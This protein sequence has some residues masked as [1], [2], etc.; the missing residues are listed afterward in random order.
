MGHG[1]R[2]LSGPIRGL[3]LIEEV[4]VDVLDHR[5]D[6]LHGFLRVQVHLGE[7]NLL[8]FGLLVPS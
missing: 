3:A 4:S 6:V 2:A 5:I 1:V 7:L 8:V